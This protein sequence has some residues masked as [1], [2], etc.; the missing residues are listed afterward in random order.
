VNDEEDDGVKREEEARGTEEEKEDEDEEGDEDGRADEDGNRK[1]DENDVL[2]VGVAL[3]RS[4]E[5]VSNL[6]KSRNAL[7]KKRY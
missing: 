1:R 5:V 7:A 6:A 2:S 4:E 3:L